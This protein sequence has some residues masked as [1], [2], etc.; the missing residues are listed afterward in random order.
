[1]LS[2]PCDELAG[3]IEN[4]ER[5]YFG[6][7]TQAGEV[8]EQL[9]AAG[10]LRG[11]SRQGSNALAAFQQIVRL[12]V[13]GLA[14]L[15]NPRSELG[16]P[17]LRDVIHLAVGA[18]RSEASNGEKRN[19]NGFRQAVAGLASGRESQPDHGACHD[20]KC[21]DRRV[22]V[23]RRVVARPEHEEQRGQIAGGT[24]ESAHE[25]RTRITGDA[26]RIDRG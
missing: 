13:E 8:E 3:C 2:R 19:R 5:G 1:M 6:A 25:L 22:R 23:R 10:F 20:D 4:R 18:K 7:R 26:G 15:G 9:A 16:L 12:T 17:V 21:G 11:V 24:R 14:Q